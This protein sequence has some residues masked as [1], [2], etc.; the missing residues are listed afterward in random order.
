MLRPALLVL[1]LSIPVAAGAEASQ[2]PFFNVVTLDASATADVATDTLTITLF[3]EEQGPDPTALATRINA[4]LEEAL[5]KAKPTAGVET[6]SGNYQTNPIYDRAN[7]ITGWRIRAEIVL[8]SRDFKAAGALASRLQ[9][10][11]KL[12]AMVF[13]LSR[14]A[15]EKAEAALLTDALTR[16][17]A[18]AQA[19]ARTLGFPGYTLGQVT[20]RSDGPGG[21]PIAYRGMAMAAMA[22]AAPPPPVPIEGGKNAVTVHVSGSVI[23]GPGK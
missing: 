22:D 9:P 5:A 14:E 19:I 18:K 3:T 16:Y 17:Q 6:R 13:S 20:V 4:R 15:R 2:Q 23:L 8:E 10:A 1:L 11:M 21:A 12:S 7:Q